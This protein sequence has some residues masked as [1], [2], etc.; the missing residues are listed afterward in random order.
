M[1]AREAGSLTI[2]AL[3]WR[4]GEHLEKCFASLR[5]LL[6]FTNADT[7]IVL[8]ASADSETKRIARRV[9]RR[10]V[11]NQF[12]N[13]SR[14]RNAALNSVSTEWVFFIDAD[15]RI[16]GALAWEIAATLQSGAH[17]AYRVPRRNF[18]FGKEVRHTGWSPDYQVRLLRTASCRY[19]ATQAVHEVPLVEGSTG[20]LRHPLVHFN[21][22]TWRQFLA[23]QR[24]YAP[25]E[26]RALYAAGQR[27]RLRSLAGQP[28]REFKRRFIDYEG[29]RDGFLGFGLSLAMAAYKLVVY[30][31]LF[32]LAGKS[33]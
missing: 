26:A 29:Y 11:T 27:A 2:A 3:A 10:V 17:A 33:L 23:K 13:F 12:E 28:A 20:T 7:L 9:A 4:E 32:R 5:P 6:E 14:Q 18:L 22:E 24:A 1:S 19:D 31:R 25:L 16:T 8:D 15:E 30:W 21:Y